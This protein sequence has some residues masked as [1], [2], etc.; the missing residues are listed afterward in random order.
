MAKGR[1]DDP[2]GVAVAR[3]AQGHQ[4]DHAGPGEADEGPAVEQAQKHAQHLHAH[5]ADAHGRQQADAEGQQKKCGRVAVGDGCVA[6]GG[7][8]DLY[9]V[10]AGKNLPLTV[11]GTRVAAAVATSHPTIIPPAGM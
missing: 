7:L 6:H 11:E 8:L 5:D 9:P 10:D 1:C 3:K 4:T 2:G